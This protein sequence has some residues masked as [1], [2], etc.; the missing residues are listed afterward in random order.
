[1]IMEL[2]T[3]DEPGSISRVEITRNAMLSYYV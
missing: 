2:G 3:N 1:M